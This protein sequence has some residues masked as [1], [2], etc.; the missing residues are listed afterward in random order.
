VLNFIAV[1]FN[2]LRRV[3]VKIRE[4]LAEAVL[5]IPVWTSALWWPLLLSMAV[6]WFPLRSDQSR[7]GPSG[8]VEPWK[9][10]WSLCTVRLS[11]TLALRPPVLPS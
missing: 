1:P 10:R 5:V 11:G 6:D 3:L 7:A 2:L 4:E 9:G 8:L